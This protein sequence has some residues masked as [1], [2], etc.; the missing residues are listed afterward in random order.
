MILERQITA[1][2]DSI[3]LRIKDNQISI[4]YN[5][6]DNFSG[7]GI[8]DTWLVFSP[9]NELMEAFKKEIEKAIKNKK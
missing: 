7:I 6:Q 3:N 9:S 8:G 1:I 4:K 5:L 2:P